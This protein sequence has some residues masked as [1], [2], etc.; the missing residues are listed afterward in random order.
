M[1]KTTYFEL[2]EHIKPSLRALARQKGLDLDVMVNN[3]LLDALTGFVD[4]SVLT[5]DKF[6]AWARENVPV[7]EKIIKSDY[8]GLLL[9]HHPGQ[10]VYISGKMFANWLEDFALSEGLYIAAGRNAAGRWVLFSK[11]EIKPVKVVRK[12]IS[13]N[14]FG[15]WA[16]KERLGTGKFFRKDMYRKLVGAFPG[17]AYIQQRTV[18]GWLE[19]YAAA[20]GY[21][22]LQGGS[23]A[24]HWYSLVINDGKNL[25]QKGLF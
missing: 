12:V 24:G 9:E 16:D 4:S 8:L 18:W 17:A 1:K 25:L 22:L 2:D 5:T 14:D 11:K 6:I 20:R 7:G 23:G 13:E 21:L 3:I 19:Q 10:R 15:R